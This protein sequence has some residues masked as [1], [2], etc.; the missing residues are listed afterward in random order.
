MLLFRVFLFYF[1][2]LSSGDGHWGFK[3]WKV[4]LFSN[5]HAWSVQM[6]SK[7]LLNVSTRYQVRALSYARSDV[8]LKILGR[9]PVGA[10]RNYNVGFPFFNKCFYSVWTLQLARLVSI[11]TTLPR[12][13]SYLIAFLCLRRK[14]SYLMTIP[15]TLRYL[16]PFVLNS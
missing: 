6:K 8:K 9:S 12:T 5:V 3:Y 13:T 10:F 2:E 1:S 4:L 14:K 15:S 11:P 16:S 7:Y